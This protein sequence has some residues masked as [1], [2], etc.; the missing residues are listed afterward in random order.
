MRLRLDLRYDGTDFAGWA[1]QPGQRTVQGTLEQTIALVLRLTD[2]QLTAAG[3]TDAGV[4]ARGQVAHVDLPDTTESSRGETLP[5]D[6]ALRRRLPGALPS[7]I[8]A[9]AITVASV[10]FDARFSAVWRRYVYRLWDDPRQI[11]PLARRQVAAV[12]GRLDQP[13]MAAAAADLVGLHDFTAFCRPRPGASSIR[14]LLQLDVSRDQ[15][16]LISLTVAADA[17]CHSMV[18]GLVGAL[19]AVGQGRR[20]RAWLVG[21]LEAERRAND[22]TVMPA[23]GL[24][25]EAVGYPPDAELAAR[26]AAARARRTATELET[27]A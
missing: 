15:S 8:V 11:D 18:R 1:R 3:R 12:G 14:R 6:E 2:A 23:H 19:V 26:A 24:T 27:P 21:L 16:G 17:F 13:A 25:L 7:D 22:I 4:H 10:D 20:D 9:A 5:T